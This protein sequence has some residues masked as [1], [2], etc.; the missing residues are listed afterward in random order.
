MRLEEK[1]NSYFV[2][3]YRANSK[4]VLNPSL[5]YSRQGKS[6]EFLFGSGI[7]YR[8]NNNTSLISQL[9]YRWNDAVIPAFGINYNSFTLVVNY[10]INHSDLNVASNYKGGFEFSLTYVWNKKQVIAKTKYCPKYTF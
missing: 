1:Y 7:N 3:F 5:L 9:F 4:L 6:T 2:S 8:M 10:D